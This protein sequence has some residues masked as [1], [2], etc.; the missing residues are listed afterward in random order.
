MS[1]TIDNTEAS[2][3][4]E[5]GTVTAGQTVQLNFN[6][7]DVSTKQPIADLQPYLGERGH[8][9]IVRQ[10]NEIT[11][12]NYIDAHAMPDTGNG[13]IQ[14]MTSFPKPGKYK[15]WGQFNRNG[16]IVVAD[17]WVNVT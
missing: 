2:L 6:L 12:A 16:K 8:L 9:V 17:F 5:P 3:Q 10:A 15:L 1:K 11:K 13:K 7:V 14:F 4:I